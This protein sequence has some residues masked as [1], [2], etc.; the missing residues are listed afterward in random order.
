VF[1]KKDFLEALSVARLNSRKRKFDQSFDMLINFK[2]MNFKKPESKIE[3]DVTLPHS[4]GKVG[5]AKTLVFVRDKLFAQKLSGKASKIIFEDDIASLKKKDVELLLNEY[6]VF[7]AEGPVLLTV[8]K[9]LGQILAP[10]GKMPK[11]ITQD[12][13]AFDEIVSKLS[14]S[15]KVTNRKG[16]VL[17]FVQILIGKESN[18]DEEICE[19]ALHAFKSVFD[20]VGKD[21]QK[22]RSVMLKLTMGAPVLVGETSK[23]KNQNVKPVKEVKK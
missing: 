2:G 15:V 9:Y 14:T 4:T 17:P 1:E 8:G 20:A 19:N 12:I 10:K 23:A 5:Q 3:L 21:R 22:I 11:P 18:K 6:P 16:K 13:S 7:L